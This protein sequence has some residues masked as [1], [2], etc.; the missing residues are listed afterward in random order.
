MGKKFK[1]ESMGIASKNTKKM[2]AKSKGNP[3]WDKQQPLADE[4]MPTNEELWKNL[5]KWIDNDK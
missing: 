5:K 1:L 3:L 4:I 2:H